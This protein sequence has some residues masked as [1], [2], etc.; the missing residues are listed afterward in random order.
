MSSALCASLT[1]LRCA[2][3][4]L[5]RKKYP[6]EPRAA[7]CPTSLMVSSYPLT[8]CLNALTISS[9]TLT[10]CSFDLT[11]GSSNV[12]LVLER[13]LWQSLGMNIDFRANQL[14]FSTG[15]HVFLWEWLLAHRLKTISLWP[16]C[17]LIVDSIAD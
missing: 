7:F 2:P 8:I 9:N 11:V 12:W 13:G 16:T 10:D 17:I 5:I 4:V 3:A 14:Q 1:Q 15:H 6:M